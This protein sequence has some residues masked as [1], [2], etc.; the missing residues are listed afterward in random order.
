[1]AGQRWRCAGDAGTGGNEWV[2]A[3]EVGERDAAKE[4]DVYIGNNSISDQSA[5]PNLSMTAP[6]EEARHGSMDGA[7]Q[8]YATR[9]LAQR[10]RP[11]LHRGH[12]LWALPLPRPVRL[13][14]WPGSSIVA[15]HRWPQSSAAK[16][17]F[18]HDAFRWSACTHMPS[19]VACRL[20]LFGSSRSRREE[21]AILVHA[22][23]N[24][25]KEGAE[26]VS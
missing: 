20:P 10:R 7:S 16:G 4:S 25:A 1:V 2:G 13:R 3:G 22:D 26:Q 6:M 9:G 21:P 15:C 19:L 18:P 12:C 5:P 8:L 17:Y 23:G 14:F 11:R 24:R